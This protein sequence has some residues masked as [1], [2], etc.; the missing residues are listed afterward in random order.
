[1]VQVGRTFHADNVTLM[2]LVFQLDLG[3]ACA[4][5]SADSDLGSTGKPAM[6]GR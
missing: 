2:F 5:R 6:E 3:D 1:M 4:G